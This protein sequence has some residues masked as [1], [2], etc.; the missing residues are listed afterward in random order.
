MANDK[1]LFD[2]RLAVGGNAGDGLDVL[3]HTAHHLAGSLGDGL[4]L[5]LLS[6][7]KL[8]VHGLG[9]AGDFAQHLGH[10]VR[11]RVDHRCGGLCGCA[12]CFPCTGCRIAR[13]GIGRDSDI[14]HGLGA[15]GKVGVGRGPVGQ[16]VT[17]GNIGDGKT[18]SGCGS[19]PVPYY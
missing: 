2:G 15:V 17:A 6:V 19:L 16:F 12:R 9:G 13:L 3:Q 5:L 4:G 8:L 18:G 1:Y 11:V 14:R 10:R 7:G